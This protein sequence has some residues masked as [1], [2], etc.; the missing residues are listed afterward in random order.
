MLSRIKLGILIDVHCHI[1]EL[2]ILLKKVLVENRTV[3]Q[4]T[5]ISFSVLGSTCTGASN[6]T[7]RGDSNAICSKNV[8]KCQ[9]GYFQNE[10]EICEK[11]KHF[12][13]L[14]VV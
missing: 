6:C 9:P 2:Y 5:P 12:L 10:Y 14:A 1:K 4:L 7:V 8:C 11:S 13:L 3:M